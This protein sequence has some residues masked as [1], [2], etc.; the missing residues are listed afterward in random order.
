MAGGVPAPGWVGARE[1][2]AGFKDT[3]VDS[4]FWVGGVLTPTW[5]GGYRRYTEGALPLEEIDPATPTP[6]R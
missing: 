6:G 2:T 5:V 4:T 3:G 1:S